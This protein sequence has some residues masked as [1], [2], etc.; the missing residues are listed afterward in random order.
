MKHNY[1]FTV[2]T[3]TYNM[4][5]VIHRVYESLKE[6]TFRDFE[7]IIVD[8][9]ST[10]MT[11]ELV[12]RWQAESYLEIRYFYQENSGKHVARN[13]ALGFARG[14]LFTTMDADDE[15]LPI[16]LETFHKAWQAIEDKDRYS[17]LACPCLDSETHQVVGQPFPKPVLDSNDLE[18]KY[19]Y[20]LWGEK[21]G[22]C[23]T[24]VLREFLFPEIP[25]QRF[26]MESYVW[27]QIAVKYTHRYIDVPLRIYHT[28][29][30]ESLTKIPVAF[31][32]GSPC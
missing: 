4:G 32:F 15:F 11:R 25:G 24:S 6:Q 3:P 20:G 10:D 30:P 22:A 5:R 17:G 23:R 26:F 21:W 14:E 12:S 9:G 27:N 8:D 19:V 2:F 29:T 13:R 28:D 31:P 7:W 16:A 18:A 1:S